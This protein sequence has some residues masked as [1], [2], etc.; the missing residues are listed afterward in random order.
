MNPGKQP[1]PYPFL[2]ISPTLESSALAESRADNIYLIQVLYKIEQKLEK[3]Q[4]KLAEKDTPSTSTYNRN[5]A[6]DKQAPLTHT[7]RS[8]FGHTI[9]VP[10][11]II[12]RYT[13]RNDTLSENEPVPSIENQ[14]PH[15]PASIPV[16]SHRTVN[17]TPTPDTG[18]NICCKKT[19]QATSALHSSF[20]QLRVPDLATKLSDSQAPG[21]RI[22]NQT[23]GRS[24]STLEPLYLDDKYDVY[25]LIQ[26]VVF[27]ILD[28][29]A[30]RT[31]KIKYNS[32]VILP[33]ERFFDFY[34]KFRDLAVQAEI[35]N[36]KHFRNNLFDKATYR[37]TS[38]SNHK[39]AHSTTV[40]EYTEILNN[41]D[42]AYQ[43]LAATH[44]LHPHHSLQGTRPT[45]SFSTSSAAIPRK[46]TPG[47]YNRPVAPSGMPYRL[48]S[49]APILIPRHFSSGPPPTP[50][51]G[52]RQ[53]TPQYT[54]RTSAVINKIDNKMNP[55]L[56]IEE[57]DNDYNNKGF[58]TSFKKGYSISTISLIG[59]IQDM[60]YLDLHTLIGGRYLSFPITLVK[61]GIAL[62]TQGLID[63]GA[64]GYALI[65]QNL[66]TDY[67]PTASYTKYFYIDPQTMHLRDT[68]NRKHQQNAIRQ[69][70][71]IDSENASKAFPLRESLVVAPTNQIAPSPGATRLANTSLASAQTKKTRITSS[72]STS[73]LPRTKVPSNRRTFDKSLGFDLT[74]M[75][76]DLREPYSSPPTPIIRRKHPISPNSR[77]PPT[78]KSL[79]IHEISAH[80]FEIAC[81]RSS[82]NELFTCTFQEVDSLLDQR[83]LEQDREVEIS[84]IEKVLT[85]T[86][87]N[88]NESALK[89][90]AT[91]TP[92]E[93]LAPDKYASFHDIFSK[94]KSNILPPYRTYNHAITFENSTETSLGYSPL[95]K[96]SINK[97]KAVKTYLTDNLAK[98]F[99]EPN[100]VPFAAPILFIKKANSSLRLYIDYHKLNAL[101]HKDRYPLPLIDETLARLQGAKIYTKLDIRQAFHRIRMDPQSEEYTTF[102][103]RY[104][105]YKCKVLPFGL[106]NGPAT[107]QR[108]M[109]DIL[110]DYLDDFCTA[111]LNDILIYSEN[112]EDH[113]EHVQK[114]LTR[115]R[116]AGLQVD[117][118]KSEFDVTRTKYLGFIISTSGVE[119]DPNKVAIVHNWQYP[120]TLKGIQSFLGFC[121]F[122]RRF[123]PSYGVIA[124]ALV[125]LTRANVPFSFTKECMNSF[126]T[127]QKQLTSAPLLQHYDYNLE[128]MLET[129]ASDSVIATVLSQKHREQWLPV[130]YFSKTMLPAELNYPIHDKELTAIVKAFGHWRS[131]LIGSRFN[132]KVFT[133]HKALKYFITSKQLN[134]RQ[135]R[136]AELLADF[137]FLIMYRPSKENPLADTLSRK[138]DDIEVTNKQKKEQRIL[139]L[140]TQDQL[141]PRIQT[142]LESPDIVALEHI[143]PFIKTIDH[144]LHL[145]K[146]SE[147]LHALRKEALK[148]FSDEDK[149]SPYTIIDDLLLYNEKLVIPSVENLRTLLIRDVHTQ[150]LSAHPS[151][152]KTSKMLSDHY[153]WRGLRDDVARYIRNCEICRRSKVPRDKKPGLLKPLSIPQRPW[154][155]ITID[156]CSFNKDKY[157]YN[158]ILVIIDK[159]TKQAISIPCDIVWLDSRYYKTQQPSRKLDFPITGKY[160]I[161][162]KI[163]Q[164]Y[165][166]AL[167]ATMH[168]FDMFPPEKLRLAPEDPLPE[169]INPPPYPVNITGEEEWEVEEVL[170]SKLRYKNVFYQVS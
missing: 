83:L 64:N 111:Y 74:R 19:H 88:L 42:I 166:L 31:T 57:F 58:S 103:T 59:Q 94:Q 89:L 45:Q 82:K 109:N 158:N 142:L 159:L 149:K 1:G 130:A 156:F 157:G 52:F 128:S 23:E 150:P 15:R 162:E 98:G 29:S 107:Y 33:R 117:L 75:S 41:L 28:P 49:A 38:T 36:D 66:R 86:N 27:V 90:L 7:S 70:T 168:I 164:S 121:N 46:S 153:Y 132:V 123:I 170:A 125:N 167:P 3:V 32:L 20:Q 69:D 54:P 81:T 40:G 8:P 55:E 136:I 21:L 71:A 16:R 87:R 68:I 101:T 80:A 14:G 124:S 78:A 18:T 97:L 127:L 105:S 96:M 51:S 2:P 13:H 143:K 135:A 139:P 165:Q 53:A 100:Q 119:V 76:R 99:I 30:V 4:T 10:G 25:D 72:T 147:T 35:L 102:R 39:F 34:S 61:D 11:P 133:D 113:N 60:S 161:V 163:G 6:S 160:E 48:P 22:Y 151:D 24:R 91:L 137:N 77:F 47:I 129:D 108:Y 65:D 131:E 106:T 95:Y 17:F 62:K 146:T 43:R 79:D 73:D 126:D 144:I 114:I 138:D 50:S 67:P 112:V 118:K 152:T 169:Q 134:N 104:G 154:Q 155:H 115:L 120:T 110:F 84:T 5:G 92:G 44:T 26:Q 140:F 141:D 116:A 12:S 9:Q 148:P 37:L 93:P 85:R 145:N 56:D 63:S 122:Y